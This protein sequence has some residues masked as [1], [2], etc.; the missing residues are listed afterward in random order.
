MQCNITSHFFFNGDIH[1]TDNEVDEKTNS[2][3]YIAFSCLLIIKKL[4]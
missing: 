1:N 3:M 4:M 2:V